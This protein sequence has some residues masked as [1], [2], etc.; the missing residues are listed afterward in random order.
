MSDLSVP[1]PELTDLSRPFWE[2]LKRDA[3]LTFQ[4]C[5]GCGHAWLPARA[6][7]PAC[8][9]DDWQRVPAVGGATLVS[10]VV[11]RHAYHPAF[12][13]RLPY[14]VAVVELDEGPRMISNIVRADPASLRIE[15]R[16]RLL[17]EDENGTAVA[18]FTPLTGANP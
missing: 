17:I 13:A 15:Q 6:Q 12:E 11:Y 4:R 18:R 2:A 3:T 5:D 16:L 1:V 14:T 8:L 9:G 10:W 7:C